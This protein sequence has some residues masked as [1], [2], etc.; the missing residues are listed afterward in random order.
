MERITLTVHGALARLGLL[1]LMYRSMLNAVPADVRRDMEREEFA[2][3]I[4][5]TQS[6]QARTFLDDLATWRDDPSE[7]GAIPVT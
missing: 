4:V 2:P 5:R 6:V 7:L 3:D 1:G